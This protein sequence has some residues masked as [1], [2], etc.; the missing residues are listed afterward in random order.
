MGRTNRLVAAPCLAVALFMTAVT[1]LQAQ[2][3]S[4]NAFSAIRARN[5]GPAIMSGRVSDMAGFVSAPK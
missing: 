4:S 3:P 1:M 2:A 5:I